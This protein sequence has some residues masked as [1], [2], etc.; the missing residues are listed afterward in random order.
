MQ[1]TSKIQNSSGSNREKIGKKNV[2]D[3][4]AEEKIWKSSLEL[5]RGNG[6]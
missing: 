4:E 1:T 5:R 3:R 2:R 6:N